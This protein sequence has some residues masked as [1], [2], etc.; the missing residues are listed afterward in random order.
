MSVSGK[1]SRGLYLRS[2]L[3]VSRVLSQGALR[4]AQC[5]SNRPVYLFAYLIASEC[6]LIFPTLS[7]CSLP[8]LTSALSPDPSSSL[9]T[10]SLTHSPNLFPYPLSSPLPLPS[11]LTS[12]HTLS[13]HLFPYPLS[14][15]LPLPSLL[16][17]LSLQGLS[18]S[19]GW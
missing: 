7:T 10:T 8:I 17:F 3:D 1:E 19:T 13:P 9:L 15:P 16:T 2:L 4:A 12:F 6:V 5:K 14:S 11:L 18:R